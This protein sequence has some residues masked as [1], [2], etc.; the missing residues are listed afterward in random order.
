MV[1]CAAQHITLTFLSRHNE[2]YLGPTHV[3][4]CV[5]LCCAVL[6]EFLDPV[7]AAALVQEQDYSYV[8]DCID[9]VAPK[10]ALLLAGHTA[11]VATISS[12]GAGGRMDPSRVRLA[13]ISETHND[14]FAAVVRKRLRKAGV[15]SGVTVV[16]SDEAARPASLAL[17]EQQ[18]KRSYFGTS[19]YIPGLFGLYIAS[20]VIRQVVEPG[21][22]L[23]KPAASTTNSPRKSRRDAGSSKKGTKKGSTASSG[24]T[25]DAK[26]TTSSSSTV[27][28]SGSVSDGSS[29]CVSSYE[30]SST[31]LA[32][33]CAGSFVAH[34]QQ[35][36]GN[37][38]ITTN[39]SSH[40]T[41]ALKDP[42]T[43]PGSEAKALD[44]RVFFKS[45]ECVEGVGMGFDGEGL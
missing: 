8:I 12:M 32:S 33:S 26:S 34:G 35:Q 10:V 36:A 11:G 42:A 40:A 15:A 1:L 9:S 20:H 6:Q 4:C 5:T 23:P 17:T 19:S 18:Y 41:P 37:S 14:A 43:V 44:Q 7:R 2:A 30:S 31:G 16:F 29:A 27:S 13:D 39:S 28:S 25:G 3:L 24:S 22:Q 21:Y 38:L 45:Y